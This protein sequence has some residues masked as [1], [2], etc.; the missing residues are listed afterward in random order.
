MPAS[1]VISAA[2]L[3]YVRVRVDAVEAGAQVDPTSLTVSMAF[4][5]GTGPPVVDDLKAASWET[6]ATTTP[7]CYYARCLVGPDGAVELKPGTYTVWVKIVDS[8]E[9]PLIPAGP[10]KVR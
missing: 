3:E 4:M 5:V 7:T 8:P 6:N 2:S 10:L 9:A 1:A